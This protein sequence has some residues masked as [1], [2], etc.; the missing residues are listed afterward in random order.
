MSMKTK[1]WKLLWCGQPFETEV[2]T[3]LYMIVK[4]AYNQRGG[5]VRAIS[6]PEAANFLR[7]MLDKKEGSGKDQFLGDR[8]WLSE[9]VRRYLRTFR[10][11][12][13]R[14]PSFSSSMRRKKLEGSGYKIGGRGEGGG[15]ST[16]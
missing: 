12:P 4:V 14:S 15:F 9:I 3:K 16:R 8:D 7:R 5:G 2:L 6:F 13:F 1:F 11:G 10:T